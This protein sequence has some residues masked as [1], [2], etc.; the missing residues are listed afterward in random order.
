MSK[1]NSIPL[2]LAFTPNYFIPAA[3]CLHSILKHS[4]EKDLFHVYVLLSEELPED[5]KQELG[6]MDE[7]RMTFSFIN[8]EGQLSDIYIDPKY[9]IAA[10]YRLLL[11]ELLPQCDKVIYIDCDVVV[12]NNLAELY[13]STDLGDNYLAAVFEATL[14]FQVEYLKKIGCEPGKYFN[15]GFLMMN[16]ALLRSDK[17]SGKFIEAAKEEGLQFPDQDVLNKLCENRVLGLPPYYNSIRT[18]YLPQYKEAFL[19]YYTES[20]WRAIQEHGTIHY[21]GT[22]PWN[23]F[24]VQFD[25]WWRYYKQLPASLKAKDKLKFNSRL[26][27]LVFKSSLLRQLVS[28]AIEVYRTVRYK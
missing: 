10:S 15:S 23:T 4:S 22:K 21:T 28:R 19:K 25:V 1:I 8:L 26:S 6:K 16:L 14:D 2:V 12:R 20:D 18:F 11:P 3:V 9:T 24:A 27:S 7:K 5:M 17:M 13:R